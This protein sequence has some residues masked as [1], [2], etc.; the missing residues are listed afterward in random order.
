MRKTETIDMEETGQAQHLFVSGIVYEDRYYVC[1]SV[2]FEKETGK[3][4]F[5]ENLALY[6]T[7]G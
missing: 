2:Y 5:T 6:K 3:S 4:R 7:V 1:R